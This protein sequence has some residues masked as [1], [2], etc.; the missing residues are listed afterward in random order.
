MESSKE[1]VKEFN[2]EADHTESKESL[3]QKLEYLE[4]RADEL[5]K[6][7]ELEIFDY[8]APKTFDSICVASFQEMKNFAKP[9]IVVSGIA[10]AS[11][12]ILGESQSWK[13]FQV[14]AANPLQFRDRIVHYNASRI[15]LVTYQQLSS[16]INQYQ[17]ENQAKIL[18]MSVAAAGFAKWIIAVWNQAKAILD[19]KE[20]EKKLGSVKEEIDGVRLKME[21]YGD[22]S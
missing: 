9:P 20:V 14:Y 15:N 18:N 19:Q 7:F 16:L 1:E 6:Q 13:A 3:L 12:L 5:E 4:S 2:M 8:E 21:N 22:S 10:Q 17:L 11:L